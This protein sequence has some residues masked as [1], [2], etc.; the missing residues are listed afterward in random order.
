MVAADPA[1]PD[2]WLR[3]PGLLR[4]A[5]A[6]LHQNRPVDAARLLQGSA[7]RRAHDGL[8]AAALQ[9]GFGFQYAARAGQIRVREVQPGS[10]GNAVALLPDDVILKVND[11]EMNAESAIRFGK[12]IAG[13]AGTKLKLT[14]RHAG[15]EESAGDR[16]LVKEPFLRDPATWEPLN[17]L[18]AAV[19]LRLAKEPRNAGLLEA[20]RSWPASG[21]A[22]GPRWPTTPPRWKRL[23]SRNPR[24]PLPTSCGYMA[25]AP[26][27][28]SRWSSGNRRSTITPGS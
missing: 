14:V 19:D 17:S 28:I 4:L 7:R 12:L 13:P 16:G 3:T 20:A 11:I 27:L 15:S 25:A 18:R 9:L 1:S 5:N 10:S 24:L 23:P 26:A 6:L 8:P 21:P 22:P 2:G